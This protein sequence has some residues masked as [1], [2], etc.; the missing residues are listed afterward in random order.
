MGLKKQVLP[1]CASAI[2]CRRWAA[3]AG[4]ANRYK[5]SFHEL[6]SSSDKKTT[7]CPLSVTTM[8][9]FGIGN[10]LLDTVF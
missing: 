8:V 10:N 1:A 9:G 3:F 4:F 2:E 6:N 5:V 7:C